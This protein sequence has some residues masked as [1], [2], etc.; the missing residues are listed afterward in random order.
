MGAE[1]KKTLH[2]GG[3]YRHT[4][5]TQAEFASRIKDETLPLVRRKLV[6]QMCDA[7]A[8]QMPH[9]EIVEHL[10]DRMKEAYRPQWFGLTWQRDQQVTDDTK[11]FARFLTWLGDVEVLSAN[12]TVDVETNNHIVSSRVDLTVRFKNGR[13]GAFI[14]HFR[15]ADKSPG[16]VSLHTCTRSDLYMLCAKASLE[17]KYRGIAVTLVYL[18]NVDDA[19][20]RINSNFLVTG[21]KR[22]NAF[23]DVFE[24]FY[25]GGYFC[26]GAMLNKIEECLAVEPKPNCYIC[27]YQKICK[28]EKAKAMAR[29]QSKKSEETAYTVP[30]FTPSQLKVVEHME[31]PMRVVAGPGSGK[32]ATLIGRIRHLIEEGV[33]P[34]FILAITFTREAAGEL[35]SRC[36]AF[37]DAGE[38][39]EIST[40]H[41]LGFKILR[42]NKR[43]VGNVEL[44]TKPDAMR[45][46]ETIIKD[47]EEPMK[48]LD[49]K[50]LR[51]K[52]GLY[53][54]CFKLLEQ[55]KLQ[56]REKFM[57]INKELDEGFL[58]FA[59]LYQAVVKKRGFIT[60]DE[61]ISKCVKL[62]A[63][64]PEVLEGLRRRYKYIMVDEFQD[65]DAKQ[66]NF[67]YSLA[68]HEN[69]VVVGDDDQSI[70]SF[71]G[72]SNQFMLDFEKDF[73]EATTVVLEENFR[74]KAQ[75]V[76]FAQHMIHSKKTKRLEK[77]IMAKR[78]GGSAPQHFKAKDAA[79]LER[80]V[81]SCLK[82]GYGY[83]DISVLAS[84]NATL[85]KMYAEVHFPCVLGKS[86]LIDSAYFGVLLD[87]LYMYY[88]GQDDMHLVHLEVVLEKDREEVKT[89]V[90]TCFQRIERD[91]PLYLCDY[92]AERLDCENTAVT[93]AI[94]KVVEQYH[95][96]NNEQFFETLMYM[97]DY[98]DETRL[99]PE[100]DNKVLLSTSHESKGMEWP[101]VIIIDDFKDEQSAETIRLQYVSITRPKDKLI[102]LSDKEKPLLAA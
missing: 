88:M 17:E 79:A 44:L 87:V 45:I 5:K 81:A 56:G 93:D 101:C 91:I 11:R 10:T 9:K 19:T 63:K 78:K 3:F 86:F 50:K 66:A 24:D 39:P 47:S 102:V 7:L 54:T 27:A 73:K 1:T 77:K 35:K 95:V 37:C 16:G 34:D 65:V 23:S 52:G 60:F 89:F 76:A 30:E 90:E 49:Y 2:V 71:R 64:H 12:D 25:E 20:N 43:Y 18:S 83:G 74:T 29:I 22:S 8:A 70:Y 55:L 85:E 59:K 38:M 46:I 13:Y 94:E 99:T 21:S 96:R 68:A 15:E 72:G 58:E 48:G 26:K 28:A 82:D 84:R 80:A 40:I 51:G 31:G 53:D 67:I 6:M 97:S 14:I 98:A 57:Q 75:L 32:T 61:Q 69:I 42:K 100:T 41:A 33:A 4:C 92:I 36:K 62:F